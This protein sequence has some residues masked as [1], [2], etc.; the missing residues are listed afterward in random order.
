MLQQKHAVEQ[1]GLM[2]LPLGCYP[3]AC[4]SCFPGWYHI[5]AGVE[6]LRQFSEQS[7]G[8]A[9]HTRRDAPADSWRAVLRAWQETS[10]KLHPS[11]LPLNLWW[12]TCCWWYWG[13]ITVCI[14]GL[15]Y[16][17]VRERKITANWVAVWGKIFRTVVRL[18]RN[19]P[20]KPPS[21]HILAAVLWKDLFRLSA[22]IM[23]LSL[24][25]NIAWRPLFKAIS[26]TLARVLIE[27]MYTSTASDCQSGSWAGKCSLWNYVLLAQFSIPFHWCDYWFREAAS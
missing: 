17:K 27:V 1:T 3:S 24:Q 8:H 15:I 19:I 10:N 26:Q 21:L 23:I 13:C 12:H 14:Q 18:P 22:I 5:P 9:C 25:W 2:K 7:M 4:L 11:C 6:S 20:V 16:V